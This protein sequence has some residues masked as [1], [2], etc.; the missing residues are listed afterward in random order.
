MSKTSACCKFLIH[1]SSSQVTRSA[2]SPTH[3]HARNQNI[4]NTCGSLYDVVQSNLPQQ[5]LGITSHPF[6]WQPY[7]WGQISFFYKS[8]LM[9]VHLFRSK[10]PVCVASG[11]HIGNVTASNYV[12]H[13]PIGWK[14]PPFYCCLYRMSQSASWLAIFGNV[15][16]VCRYMFL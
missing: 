8:P 1:Q 12:T 14:L 5:P 16:R 6:F 13:T 3:I 10:S 9:A 15:W 4:G 2:E 11:H 7:S